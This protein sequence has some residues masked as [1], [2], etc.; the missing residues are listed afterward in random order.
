MGWLWMTTTFRRQTKKLSRKQ[1][2]KLGSRLTSDIGQLASFLGRQNHAKPEKWNAFDMVNKAKS[3]VIHWY[4]KW[5]GTIFFGYFVHFVA[6]L[7][8]ISTSPCYGT[9]GKPWFARKA[10]VFWQIWVEKT[11]GSNNSIESI[12][13][14]WRFR[15]IDATHMTTIFHHQ[16]PMALEESCTKTVI[17]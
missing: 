2:R 14:S 13:I 11:R 5:T 12:S 3:V 9:K 1:R 16:W 7:F 8:E 17:G 15:K 10:W 6:I 4:H